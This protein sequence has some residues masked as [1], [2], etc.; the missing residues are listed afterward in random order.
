MKE[1][2]FYSLL[3][4]SKLIIFLL[5]AGIF[6]FVTKLNLKSEWI[7][8]SPKSLNLNETIYDISFL[9]NDTAYAVGWSSFRSVIL[10]TTNAGKDWQIEEVKGFYFFSVEATPEK[11]YIVGYSARCMCGVLYYSVDNGEKWN[12]YEFDGEKMPLTFG[13][14]KIRKDNDNKFFV[15]GFNGFIVYSEDDG[16]S[17]E[18]SKTNNNTDIF[19][20]IIF[21]NKNNYLSL[22]GENAIFSDKIFFSSNSGK[23]WRIYSDFSDKQIS[24]SGWHFFNSDTGFI[25]GIGNGQEAI[26]KTND[27][28][29]SW[30]QVYQGEIGNTLSD[31]L[32][33]DD[34]IGF[35]AKGN[36][37][38]LQT[39]DGGINWFNV[40]SPSKNNIRGFR[41][42]NKDGLNIVFAYGD[43]GTILKFSI[44]SSVENSNTEIILS[45]N[46][47]EA[48][49]ELELKNHTFYK[50][51]EIYNLLGEK[52]KMISEFGEKNFINIG[53]LPFGLYV[54][55]LYNNYG[56][57]TSIK[58]QK[59]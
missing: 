29:K 37:L 26:F 42:F 46:P 33:I 19:R 30:D 50:R 17:W 57:I 52:V 22:A 43:N 11:I 32:F 20:D 10:K 58:F 4:C 3:F 9:D 48:N 44:V 45:P 49:I 18:Y 25:F 54:L 34:M 24:I 36:G 7:D 53:N 27:G 23:T 1:K 55:V 8:V 2:L 59:K 56:E 13:A 47:A 40:Q 12:F 14:M 6:F 38:L 41:A 35:T 16:E 31:G 28:A 51:A 5:T 15:T 39:T 21:L